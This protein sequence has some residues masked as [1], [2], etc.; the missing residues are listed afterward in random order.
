MIAI[1]PNTLFM[2]VPIEETML[3]KEAKLTKARLPTAEQDK[4]IVDQASMDFKVEALRGDESAAETRR[5][6]NRWT[7]LNYGRT[8]LPVI[9]ALVAW[10]VW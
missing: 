1:V 2:I 5:L 8:I 6:L 3:I 7:V 10:S 4:S 9:G